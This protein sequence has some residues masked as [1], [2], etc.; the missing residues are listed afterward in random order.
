MVIL[1]QKSLDVTKVFKYSM[2]SNWGICSLKK[3]SF[4]RMLWSGVVRPARLEINFPRQLTIPRNL[5]SSLTDL[6]KGI[7]V[8]AS[9]FEGSTLIPSDEIMC[10]KNTRDC[11]LIWHLVL[12][13]FKPLSLTFKKTFLRRL[14]CSYKVFPPT[15]KSLWEFVLPVMS[16]ITKVTSLWKMSLVGWIP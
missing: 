1:N 6:G 10:H 11:F 7:L 5:C 8:T 4:L 3:T 16:K 15:T 12:F 13:S 9:V 2:V 14:S